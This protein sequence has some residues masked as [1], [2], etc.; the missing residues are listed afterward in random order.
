MELNLVSYGI[1]SFFK[2]PMAL[3]SIMNIYFITINIWNSQLQISFNDF[4]IFYVFFLCAY[5]LRYGGLSY[6][7]LFGKAWLNLCIM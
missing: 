3:V 7:T 2:I 6:I 4:I 1:F 5:T